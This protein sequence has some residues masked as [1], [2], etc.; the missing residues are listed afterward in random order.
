[1]IK[2]WVTRLIQ[3]YT[4]MYLLINYLFVNI[5]AIN[6]LLLLITFITLVSILKLFH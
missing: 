4:E 3:I 5:Y 1:M 6:L 2:V